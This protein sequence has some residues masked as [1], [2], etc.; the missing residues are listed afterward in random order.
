MIE[1]CV[2]LAETTIIPKHL[3]E[4]ALSANRSTWPNLSDARDAFEHTYL[5]KLLNMTDGNVTRAAFLAGRNR[6]DL[7]KLLKK[8][9]LDA[10]NF[11][12][13]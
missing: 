13:M 9:E 2:A 6:S 11:R 3:V 12:Q 7:H 4:Q 5:R 10:A 8:H 1:Q